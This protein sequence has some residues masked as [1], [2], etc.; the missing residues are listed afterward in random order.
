MLKQNLKDKISNN[1]Q[2]I[3]M[4]SFFPKLYVKVQIILLHEM[5]IIPSNLI[6]TF[7]L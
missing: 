2:N 1:V 5:K 4:L 6:F 3:L 7:N